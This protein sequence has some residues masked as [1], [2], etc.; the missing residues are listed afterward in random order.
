MAAIWAP[1]TGVAF[2][3]ERTVRKIPPGWPVMKQLVEV[4][5]MVTVPVEEM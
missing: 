3:S 4:A 1:M 5:L 2:E